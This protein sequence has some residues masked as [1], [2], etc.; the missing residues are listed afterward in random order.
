[1]PEHKCKNKYF[2]LHH[3]EDD[4]D[5]TNSHSQHQLL[6]RDLTILTPLVKNP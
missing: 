2:L 4:F 5:N 3:H 6:A 1:M